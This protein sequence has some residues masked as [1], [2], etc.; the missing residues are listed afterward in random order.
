MKQMKKSYCTATL[1]ATFCSMASANTIFAGFVDNAGDLNVVD[2][3]LT[4]GAT[5]SFSTARSTVNVSSEIEGSAEG[6]LHEVT[7]PAGGTAGKYWINMSGTNDVLKFNYAGEVSLMFEHDTVSAIF[8]SSTVKN[9]LEVDFAENSILNM[10]FKNCLANQFSGISSNNGA[11]IVVRNGFKGAMNLETAA[12]VWG[13]TGI[14]SSSSL[15]FAEGFAGDITVA[16]SNPAEIGARGFYAADALRVQGDHSGRLAVSGGTQVA[17]YYGAK[18]IEINTLSGSVS[19][20]AA[21]NLAYA[22]YSKD[23]LTIH[24]LAG[25]ISVEAGKGT[26]GNS[27]AY[28]LRTSGNMTVGDIAGTA[29]VSAKGEGGYVFGVQASNIEIGSETLGGDMAGHIF[30]NAKMVGESDEQYQD[31]L[32][33]THDVAGILAVGLT[34]DDTTGA[35]T[36]HGNLSGNIYAAGNDKVYGICALGKLQLDNVT[37]TIAANLADPNGHA[38]AITTEKWEGTEWRSNADTNDTVTL[39]TGANIVGDIRLGDDKGAD[40]DVLQLRGSGAFNYDLYGV[41][42]L[43][44]MQNPQGNSSQNAIWQ[45]ACTS[46]D[47]ATQKNVINSLRVGYGLLGV[48]KKMKINTGQVG[49]DGGLFFNLYEDGTNDKLIANDIGFQ[50][51]ATIKITQHGSLN[52]VTEFTIIEATKSICK[53]DGSSDGVSLDVADLIHIGGTALVCYDMELQDNDKKLIVITKT[54]E[55]DDFMVGRPAHKAVE[56]LQNA[57]DTD[58]TGDA[59][60]VLVAF[61]NMQEDELIEEL[62]K[63]SPEQSAT[64]ASAAAETT[65]A[66]ART[67]TVRTQSLGAGPSNM[68]KASGDTSNAYPLMFAGPSFRDENG[69]EFWSS[70]FGSLAKQDDKDGLPGYESKASGMLVGLDRMS[71]DVIL[72][73]AVGMAHAD[74]DSNQSRGTTDLDAFT[75]GVYFA[76]AP[77]Q[78]KIEGGTVYTLGLSDYKRHTAFDRIANANDVASHTFINYV[79]ASY[80]IVSDNSQFVFIPNAQLVYTYFT[81][82]AYSESKAGSL[83]LN[84]DSFD[85]DIFTAII[86]METSYQ[87]NDNLKLNALLAYKYDLMNDTP[88]VESSFQ[89]P[90]STPFRTVGI[91]TDKGVVEIGTGFDYLISEKMN[92]SLN[93]SFEYSDSMQTQNLSLGINV[94]F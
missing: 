91:E 81:Q 8:A 3:S 78:L 94:L 16:A 4:E 53:L 26:D 47:D 39:S 66:F 54:K 35:I 55:I 37:G 87:Y 89:S 57:F 5:P 22:I 32:S 1:L 42:T 27:G 92:A 65:S 30:V 48:G 90:G 23:H 60:D 11:A 18:D 10:N 68:S 93:Y 24:H 49:E 69:Y 2:Y 75:A 17:G 61:Q 46:Y 38:A 64:S 84:I 88:I 83:G 41:D 85:N 13:V 43:S 29:I 82:E 74:I 19:A 71:D 7:I 44:L 34:G 72:G 50:A 45:L 25:E 15:T 77:S 67:L 58:V 6:T 56:S 33:G 59:G 12:D 31:R 62:K 9:A 70:A 51:N 73:I 28:G 79:G 63:I 52:N 76:Y 14:V 86:G 80:D 21:K 20:K 40:G 36:I